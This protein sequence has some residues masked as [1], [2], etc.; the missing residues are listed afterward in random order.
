MRYQKNNFLKCKY[1]NWKCLKIK[2]DKKGKAIRDIVKSFDLLIE[3]V[4][5]KHSEIYKKLK[6]SEKEF[7][8]E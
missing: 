8:D 7:Y 2:K 4:E 5:Y 6:E 3:H 1:C